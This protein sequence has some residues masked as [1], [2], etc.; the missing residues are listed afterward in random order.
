MNR[1]KIFLDENEIPKQWYNIQAD[2]KTPMDPPLNPQTRQPI[3]PDD[4]KT[5]FPMELIKQ[6]ISRDRYISIPS[7]VRE[8]YRIWRP[9]PL[10]RARRLEKALK[11]PAEIYYKWE[12]VSPA[13]SHKP[14]SAVAQAY[15]NKKAGIERLVTETGAGQWG[16][17]LAFSTQLFGLKCRVYMVKC[18]YEQK[19]YRRILMQTWGAEVF[20]SPTT[21]TNAG[22]E[23]LKKDPLTS[24]SLGISIS[25]AVEDAATHDNTN[26][27]LGSVLNHVVLHQ[28]VIGLELK[29]QFELMDKYPDIICGCVGGGSNFSGTSF[30]F[31]RDKIIGKKP[32]LKVVS[33]E[34]LACPSLTAGEYRYDYGDSVGLT[35]LLKMYTLGHDFVPSP[36]HAGG[37]RYH[38]DSPLHS[39]LTKEGYMEALAYNQ[40]EVFEAAMLFAQTEGFIVA[41][42]SAHAVRA[43]IDFAKICKKKNEKKII[44]FTNSG[45]GHFDLA[46]Y[47]AFLNHKIVNGVYK[48]LLVKAAQ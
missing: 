13:G 17:A 20:S 47:D 34:P 25:E 27:A 22:R 4:L 48:K 35:P 1:T 28:T 30:P 37:L 41:P 33:I 42:E 38:G 44:V 36:I 29:K 9:S 14:N 3:S 19:P 2:L 21:L 32:D 23:T 5:I 12:G 39:K 18:S 10:Y 45:H 11:T 26:Y 7:E 43:A 31:V 24:G 46:A 16:S 6:E 8:I 15:Y 40:Q